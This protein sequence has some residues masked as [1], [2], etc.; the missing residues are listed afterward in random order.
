[1]I[2]PLEP[3]L[4]G[5]A[6]RRFFSFA[7]QMLDRQARD[8]GRIGN[9]VK[10]ETTRAPGLHDIKGQYDEY[11]ACVRVLGDLAQ[12]RWTLVESGYGLEL[13]SPRLQDQ[14]VSGPA[15]ARRRKEAIRNELRPRVLQQFSDPN[16]HKFIRRME[17][18]AAARRKSIRTLIADG[19]ELQE[20]LYAARQHPADDPARGVAL[21]HAVRPYLQL[22]DAGLRDDYTGIPLRDIWRYFRYT[23]SIP[24]TPIPGR[25]L[26]YLVRDAAHDAHAVIGIAA[27][28]NCAVQLVPRDRAIGWSASGLETALRTLFAPP[29]QRTSEPSDPAFRFQ[30]IYRWLKPHLPAGVAPSPATKRAALQRV[31]D[32]L[33][34]GVSTAIDEIECQ[35]LAS[36]EEIADPTS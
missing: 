3:K 30:G 23:W 13:H 31:A 10:D 28:S 20:R 21:R 35:G 22:V 1:M 19:A 11:T 12:L 29:E 4:E 16:V 7:R 5:L 25:S 2:I 26:L 34:Q 27:L 14:R 33:L 24:Q 17:R 6:E 9:L 36:E 18:P 8:P 32:W 15:Q